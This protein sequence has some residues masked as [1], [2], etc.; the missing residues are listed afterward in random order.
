MTTKRLIPIAIVCALA[1]TGCMAGP[2][3]AAGDASLTVVEIDWLLLGLWHGVIFPVTFVLSFFTDNVHFYLT[4]NDGGWYDLG[5]GIG[6][7]IILS[8]GI[9]GSRRRTRR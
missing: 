5:Y 6:L 1:L 8:G 3:T 2:N 9:F 7:I 4:G